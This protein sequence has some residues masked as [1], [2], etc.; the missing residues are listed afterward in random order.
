[1]M[2]TLLLAENPLSYEYAAGV[3]VLL[4]LLFL[5]FAVWGVRVLTR[6]ADPTSVK[7][8]L[9]LVAAVL[10]PVLVY[11]WLLGN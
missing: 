10:L 3:L 2:L 5:V 6:E 9:L 8:L 1:M 4:V 7:G 11:H